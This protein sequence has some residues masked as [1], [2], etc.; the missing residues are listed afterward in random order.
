MRVFREDPSETSR[1]SIA[2]K[3]SPMKNVILP[4]TPRAPSSQPEPLPLSSLTPSREPRSTSLSTVGSGSGLTSSSWNLMVA[5]L[6]DLNIRVS[7]ISSVPTGT[8]IAYNGTSC[9]SGWTEA[10]GAGVPAGP[11]GNAS[12]NLR[13]QFVRGWN[14]TAGGFGCGTLILKRA[15]GSL[16]MN[17]VPQTQR[18]SLV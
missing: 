1:S 12:L 3:I 9:P 17:D 16:V 13:G 14:S 7:A 4:I 6:N 18:V 11:G 8:V 2:L 15:K 5:D 10:A